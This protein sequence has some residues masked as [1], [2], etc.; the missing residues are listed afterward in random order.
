MA[1]LA[2]GRS[3]DSSLGLETR[4]GSVIDDGL[5]YLIGLNDLAVEQSFFASQQSAPHKHA[6]AKREL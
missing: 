5:N 3:V 2:S 6:K 4:L 1:V